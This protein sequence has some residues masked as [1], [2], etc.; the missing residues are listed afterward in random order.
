[1]RVAWQIFVGVLDW[2]GVRSFL[3]K[4]TGIPNIVFDTFPGPAY[5]PALTELRP[6]HPRRA[7]SLIPL[8]L[9]GQ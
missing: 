5:Q 2:I 9:L 3:P 8:T 7:S 6:R 4:I 1:M